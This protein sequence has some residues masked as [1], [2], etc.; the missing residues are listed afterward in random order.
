[1]SATDLADKIVGNDFYICNILD[2][3]CHQQSLL[4]S[5]FAFKNFWIYG[6]PIQNIAFYRKLIFKEFWGVTQTDFW[7]THPNMDE[8]GLVHA[9][10]LLHKLNRY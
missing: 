10:I 7:K 1:M 9:T 6:K 5:F 2:K 4:Q 8:M 3:P